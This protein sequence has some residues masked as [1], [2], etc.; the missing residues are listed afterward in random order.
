MR[1]A[2]NS[3]VGG[4]LDPALYGRQ[5]LKKYFEGA[6][7]LS[8][9]VVQRHGGIAK[10]QGTDLLFDLSTMANVGDQTEG[11]RIVPFLYDRSSAYLLVFVHEAIYFF[12][13]GVP[14]FQELHPGT[15]YS[16]SSP[17]AYDALASI[18]VTQSGDTLFVTHPDYEPVTIVRY[19]HDDWRLS[20][21]SF[22][23]SVPV[24]TGLTATSS[25]TGAPTYTY[26][27]VVSAIVDG[28]ESRPSVAATAAVTSPWPAGATVTLE[29]DSVD[30]AENYRVYKKSYG[31]YGF[32]GSTS[33]TELIDAA[34]D[35]ALYGSST[36]K[37]G[38]QNNLIAN[39]SDGK[40]DQMTGDPSY[41]E[42]YAII[43]D[44][45]GISNGI[46]IDLSS[47]KT[48][49]G[50]RIALGA[51]A[52]T[53][54]GSVVE[55]KHNVKTLRVWR[56]STGSSWTLVGDF[57]IATNTVVTGSTLFSWAAQNYRYWKISL[58][59][60]WDSSGYMCFREAELV[61]A[62]G[63]NSFVDTNVSPDTA[64]STT[65]SVNPWADGSIGYP[66]FM[67]VF[68]QRSIW[69]GAPGAPTRLM[70]SATGNL[71]AF[72]KSYPLKPDDAI[73]IS[74][75]LTKPGAIRHIVPMRN[76]N[77]LT[78]GGEWLL[79]FDPAKGLSFDSLQMSQSSYYGCNAVEPILT[80][81]S[82]LF[83]RRDGRGV[84]EY[85]YQLASDGFQA[86]D[87]SVLSAHLT[88]N[89]T[90]VAWAYQQA[91]DSLIW[92]VLSDGTMMA[93][94]Y[95]PEHEIWA[96]SRHELAGGEVQQIVSSG[97][98]LQKDD[99]DLTVSDTN[100]DEVYLVV[101]RGDG[102]FLERMRAVPA[103]DS[104]ICGLAAAMD[105]VQRVEL[106]A[107]A[108][109]FDLE[110]A[111]P[112][113]AVTVLDLV[114]GATQ[115]G[116]VASGVVT[117]ASAVRYCLVGYAITSELHTLR[118]EPLQASVQ[119][120]RK[121]VKK[122]ILR[123]RRFAGGEVG[124]LN[125]TTAEVAIPDS[126][127]TFVESEEGAPDCTVTLKTEDRQLAL[128]GM[129]N[130]DGQISLTHDDVWPFGLLCVIYELDVEGQA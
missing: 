102:L 1:M 27:Y 31:S 91:P 113:G 65:D 75:P 124:A 130:R 110:W 93:L 43:D 89:R 80:S 108:T 85:Q 53:N 86:A 18:R 87:R 28:Q 23:N 125:A 66:A 72:N 106:P 112:D 10:R 120:L 109:S 59:L 8:N 35:W 51:R 82:V 97:A 52:L 78:E 116:T 33:A 32:I 83:V 118:P 64:D 7:K 63:A 46:S 22:D 123:L 111:I 17:Y 26:S 57:P 5:D 48:V 20:T 74:L 25:E 58:E 9:F 95:M 19:D 117:V 60:A 122:A 14:V 98:L 90:I 30:G 2:Q 16:I 67:S 115:A 21:I 70:F 42:S 61:Y 55:V 54:S 11:C 50:I 45:E 129:W 13:D 71:Y 105:A 121:T 126:E 4:E 101:Q 3:F 56:S 92:A 15:Q 77:I 36:L 119:G 49:T 34:P 40:I 12:K 47:A 62:S 104:P 84:L 41:H 69:G 24:P 94:T 6:A 44:A 38:Y 99:G 37:T 39:L 96:W 107:A 114:T 127:P 81:T 73:D 100:T 29:W 103:E 68:Q 76:M 88:E 79:S 128:H